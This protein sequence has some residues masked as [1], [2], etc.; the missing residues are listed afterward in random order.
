MSTQHVT[1]YYLDARDGRP[2]SEAPLRHGPAKPLESLQIDAVDRRQSPPLI[3]GR[4]PAGDALA[5]GMASISEQDHADLMADYQAWRDTLAAKQLD[6][7]QDQALERINQA[8]QAEMDAILSRYPWAETLTFERQERE[9]RAWQADNAA[10][11][12]YLDTM[13]TERAI[14]KATLV[15]SIIAKADQYVQLSGAATGKR[16]RLEDDIQAA[17]QAGDREALES[18]AWT[19]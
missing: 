12:P 1:A 2:A 15:A 19:L 16:H 6:A 3:I 11:T 17:Y 4:I 9:A 14:D 18:V 10:P 13:L 5:P 8:Y 7:A